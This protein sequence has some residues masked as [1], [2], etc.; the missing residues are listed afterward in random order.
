[1]TE[2]YYVCPECGF[3]QKSQAEKRIK[4]GR[5]DHQYK[6]RSAKRERKEPDPE[7]G[8]GFVTHSRSS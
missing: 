1:M 7:Y 6:R 5:C 8:T 3:K 2:W 4:C